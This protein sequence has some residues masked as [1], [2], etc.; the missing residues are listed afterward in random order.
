M[1]GAQ[2]T[3]RSLWFEELLF[4]QTSLNINR[5]AIR[6]LWYIYTDI[7]DDNL[8]R[9]FQFLFIFLEML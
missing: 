4:L 6:I 9:R 5:P 3:S 1:R 8:W 2:P 7:I